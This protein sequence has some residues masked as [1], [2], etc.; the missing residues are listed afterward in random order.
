M[1]WVNLD[2]IVRADPPCEREQREVF[3]HLARKAKPRFYADENFPSVATEIL[4]L[5]GADVLTVKETQVTGHPDENHCATAL[6]LGR[7]LITCD[8]DFLDERRFPLVHCPCIVVCRFGSGTVDEIEKTFA[9]L[10]G[11][12]TGPHFF[13]KWIKIDAKRESWV[14]YIRF[15]NGTTARTRCR[16][17]RGVRQ[18]WV[19]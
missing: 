2:E 9:C 19:A 10:S 17:H 16:V 11:P 8:R 1:P 14:E 18:Q 15:G 6:R 7:I 4:R 12:F 3:E 13:D 5:R